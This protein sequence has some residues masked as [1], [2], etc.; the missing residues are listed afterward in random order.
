MIDIF[1]PHE[2]SNVAGVVLGQASNLKN[3]VGSSLVHGYCDVIFSC[4]FLFCSTESF[5]FTYFFP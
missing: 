5:N 3:G 4:M 1:I 2:S